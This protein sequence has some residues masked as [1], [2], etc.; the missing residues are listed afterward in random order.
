MERRQEDDEDDSSEE[1]SQPDPLITPPRM[2][3]MESD[4][5][6]IKLRERRSEE[7]ISWREEALQA[8]EAS[9]KSSGGQL[10]SADHPCRANTDFQMMSPDQLEDRGAR[11]G[12][13]SFEQIAVSREARGWPTMMMYSRPS[14]A[15]S[16]H[17]DWFVSYEQGAD[18]IL[19][20]YLRIKWDLFKQGWP[21][22]PH[23]QECYEPGTPTLHV[24]TRAQSSTASDSQE[25]SPN[26]GYSCP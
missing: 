25:D 24:S 3:K 17:Q 21:D 22:P 4:W 14:H 20:H 6:V 23:R 18:Q 11:W 26:P 5:V 12:C 8:Q 9:L 13:I 10:W 19:Q 15:T 1:G 16:Q 2:S 7:A